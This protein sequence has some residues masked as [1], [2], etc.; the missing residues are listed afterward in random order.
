MLDYL[1]FDDVDS[2]H[3]DKSEA[4]LAPLERFDEIVLSAPLKRRCAHCLIVSG[5]ANLKLVSASAIEKK[6]LSN[7]F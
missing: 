1:L 4:S 2:D 7:Y 5:L 6:I 3:W